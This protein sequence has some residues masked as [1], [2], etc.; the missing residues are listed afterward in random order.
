MSKKIRFWATK[1]DLKSA[2]TN[3]KKMRKLTPEQIDELVKGI[4]ALK[5]ALD[6]KYK[7][8]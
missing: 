5:K 7:K 3:I 8:P 4:E 1:T 6:E 2:E